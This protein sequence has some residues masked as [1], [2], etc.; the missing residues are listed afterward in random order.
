VRL[1][2]RLDNH[3]TLDPHFYPVGDWKMCALRDE[4]RGQLGV[5][6]PKDFVIERL[7]PLA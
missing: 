2:S 7:Y 5:S 3:S 1:F 6:S 4:D